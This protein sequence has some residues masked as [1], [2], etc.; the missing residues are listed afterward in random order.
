AAE[1]QGVPAEKV[2]GTAQNDVLKEYVARGTYIY[3]PQPSLRL[4]ADLIAY[5][6]R[7][8]V[9]FN[10]I[11]LSGYHIREAGSTAPQEMAFAVANAIAYVQATVDRGVPVDDFAARLSWIFNTH[12]DFF[13]EIAKYRALRRLWA[14]VMRERFGAARPQSWMLRTHTQ[15]G[16]STLTAQQPENNI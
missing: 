3:P 1:K 14:R 13:E 4:A 15:T 6:S 2:M 10:P 16:G 8:A 5:C 7:V 12:T 11:S 9:K